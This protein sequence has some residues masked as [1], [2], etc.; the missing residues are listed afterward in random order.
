MEPDVVQKPQNNLLGENSED[1]LEVL[2][3]VTSVV[4][5]AWSLVC[6]NDALPSFNS[7]KLPHN[8]VPSLGS[9]Q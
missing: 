9:L 6:S 1:V 5:N 7:F 2:Y 8:T 3:P 4:G